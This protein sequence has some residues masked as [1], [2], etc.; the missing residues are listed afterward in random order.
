MTWPRQ[1]RSGLRNSSQDLI[2]G[3][4]DSTF[5]IMGN[6]AEKPKRLATFDD[7]RDQLE[8][9]R[10]EIIA[11]EIVPR[12]AAKFEHSRAQS[13][14]GSRLSD[15]FDRPEGRGGPGGWWIATEAE[16]EYEPHEP[17]EIAALEPFEA[18]SFDVG[19]LFGDEPTE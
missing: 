13:R 6:P 8:D 15:P 16:V 5:R 1:L 17:G 19:V 4:P 2:S 10:V 14:V 9:A 18:I 11:G 7:I 3:G 12:E